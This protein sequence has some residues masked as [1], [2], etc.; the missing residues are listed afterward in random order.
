MP[1]GRA[2]SDEI[3]PICK[4]QG[5]AVV[6]MKSFS[7]GDIFKLGTG[8]TPDE[9]LR[10]AMSADVATIVSGM[11]SIEV[12]QQNLKIADGFT[13]ISDEERASHPRQD[14]SEAAQGGEFERFKTTDWFEGE[15]G[16]HVRNYPQKYAAAD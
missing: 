11:D 12:M 3:I 9:A 8:V 16:R 1:T 15:E 10:Y 7:S 14:R 2:S 6:G 13:P 4:E 5:I